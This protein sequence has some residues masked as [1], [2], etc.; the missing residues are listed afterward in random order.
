MMLTETIGEQFKTIGGFSYTKDYI[1]IL[2]VDEPGHD[3]AGI[4]A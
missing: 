1:G 3:V 4:S 2:M